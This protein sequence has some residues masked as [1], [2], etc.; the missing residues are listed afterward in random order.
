MVK[1]YSPDEAAQAQSDVIP[2]IVVET[3]NRLLAQR[4]SLDHIVIK[5]REL[6]ELLNERGLTS[7]DVFA[8]HMLD[9][10]EMYRLCGWEVEFDKPGYNES[11]APSWKFRRNR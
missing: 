9:F 3:V 11:Y 1:P 2:D 6:V 7:S 8:Q 4:A 10:K 5:Q